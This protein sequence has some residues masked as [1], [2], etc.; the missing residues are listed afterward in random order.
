MLQRTMLVV[1]LVLSGNCAA[2]DTQPLRDP[3]RGELLYSTHCI[4]CHDLQV[5]WRD[6]RLVRNW[7][8]LRAEVYRW[9]K[10]SSLR[11][12]T[13]DIA[14]VTQYLNTRYYHYPEP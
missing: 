6:K 10:T 1:L 5:H 14:A 4:A 8:T 9:Q 2:D 11:W 3:T 7:R 13:A 12:N